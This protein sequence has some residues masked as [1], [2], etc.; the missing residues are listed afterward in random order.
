M[1]FRVAGVALIAAIVACQAFAHPPQHRSKHRPR[2]PAPGKI[3]QYGKATDGTLLHWTVFTPK[4][5]GKS[6]AVLVIHVGGFR[7]G[8][9]GDLHTAQDLADNGFVAFAI[10]YRLAPGGHLAGQVSQGHYHDQTDDVKLAVLAARKDIRC[11][12]KVAAVGGSAGAA[13]AAYVAATGVTG[14]DKVDAAVLLS[15]AYNFDDPKSLNDPLRRHF[16]GDV[17]NYAGSSLDADL[18]KASP[19]TYVTKD[20]SPLFVVASTNDPMPPGHQ[21]AML[22]KLAAVGARNFQSLTVPGSQHPLANWP[23]AKAR[24]IAFFRTY[25]SGAP[26]PSA[27]PTATQ[28][29]TPS[30]TPTATQT[31]APSTVI[32][33]NGVWASMGAGLTVPPEL[34]AN[35]GIVGVM[36]TEDWDKIERSDGVYD[37]AE[38][39]G[40]I[41][42]AKAAA[43]KFIAL[44][45]T[46]SSFD[47][48]DWLRAELKAAGQT[49]TFHSG[50]TYTFYRVPEHIYHGLVSATSPGG[51]YH[52][53]ICGRYRP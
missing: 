33:P 7:G 40:K 49:I 50:Q 26:T 28:S 31:P 3:E 24:A 16:R 47:T 22:A 37:F 13:H 18:I 17:V 19:I 8:N 38:L 43:F 52:A 12:G 30:P 27:S 53:Y 41:A 6:P 1:K 14:Q 39:D 44:G 9:M 34:A 51:Y 48:P 21:S 45:I 5:L 10:E 32:Y 23:A 15:G 2:P 36:V 11:N 46:W 35:K 25:L 29:P 42:S 4:T 20:V